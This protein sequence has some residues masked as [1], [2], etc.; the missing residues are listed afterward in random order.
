MLSIPIT[1]RGSL[2]SST[3]ALELRL[4]NQ[5]APYLTLS[6]ALFAACQSGAGISD[7]ELPLD[8]HSFAQ[9]NRVRVTHVDMDLTLDFERSV[10]K[11]S[12]R[13]DLERI[14]SRAPLVLDTMELDIHGVQGSDGTRRN[15]RLGHE[16]KSFGQ[17]MTINL[18]P[19]DNSVTIDYAT[20]PGAE[21]LQ[22]LAPEQ[23]AGG[24]HPFLFTQGQ[25]ILTRTWIPLQDTPGVRVTYA[26][27]ITA[28]APLVAVMSAVQRGRDSEGAY[29][30]GLDQPIP[31]YLIALA[32]GDLESR[33]ISERCAVWSEP[34]MLNAAHAE[35]IDTERMIQSAESLF[36]DYRWGRYDMIVLPPAF[37]FG[38]MENPLLT[39]LT[40]TMIAGDRS[41]TSLIAHELA[42]SWSGNLVT[43]A[44]WRDFWLNEGFTV[45]FEQR[46]V[47]EVYGE[48]RMHMERMLDLDKLRKTVANMEPWETVLFVDLEGKHPDDGFSSIPYDKGALFLLRLERAVGRKSLDR[49]L[50]AWFDDHAFQSV[51]TADFEAF[52]QERLVSKQRAAR[53]VD[54]ETWLHGTG[55]PADVPT[56]DSDALRRVDEQLALW[57][58]GTKG[59]RLKTSDWV[60]QQWL[61]FLRE[62]PANLSQRRLAEL[63]ETFGFTSS[64]NNEILFCWLILAIRENYS[65]ADERLEEFLITIG[66]R[67]FLQPLYEELVKT[68]EGH[69]RARRI[70]AKARP[71][72]HSVSSGTIDSIVG[73]SD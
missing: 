22:W 12:V 11:G 45:Y 42:H 69:E 2:P 53:E 19:G 68:T 13:L 48:A 41:L 46:I 6:F 23:T 8:H 37:P 61:H 3:S 34:S 63:D 29:L 30:F 17:P 73:V 31:A 38:G 56:T 43:N 7:R 57:S 58:S 28:P 47:E 62:L 33:A 51:T 44:T 24:K 49:F 50:R 39:F 5:K 16:L 52:L 40:P 4:N 70:Y 1:K 55:L 59:A 21:A 14:D 10:A 25:S 32:C 71:R 54:I 72:Y 26:A 64:G 9:P 66:R 65:P 35:L 27:R 67:K 60:T 15:F 18:A 20:A 36:G